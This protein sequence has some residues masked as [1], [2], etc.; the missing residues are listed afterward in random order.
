MKTLTSGKIIEYIKA[1]QQ[2][3]PHELNQF[4]GVSPQ[5]MHRQLQKLVASGQLVKYG[6]AP[7]VFYT[8]G[9]KL[10]PETKAPLTLPPID[11]WCLEENWLSI[12]PAGELA[13]GARSFREWCLVRS[14]DP[15]LMAGEYRTVFERYA[16]FKI[17]EV[18]DGLPK[19]RRT[20]SE[21]YLDA[22]YY[23]EFYSFER[24][25]KQN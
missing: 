20:F 9:N 14:L 5:A 23:L 10:A 22:L 18:I 17:H 12:T 11:E 24:F 3:A 21:G 1:N 6:K 16:Q 4:L 8:L 2:V 13:Q 7:K 25:V 19:L 15:V